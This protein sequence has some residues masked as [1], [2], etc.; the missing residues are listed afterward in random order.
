MCRSQLVDNL[1]RVRGML[2]DACRR[3][4]RSEEAVTLVGVTKYVDSRGAGE[5]AR[6]GCLDLGESRPQELVRKAQDLAPLPVRWHLVGHLQRNKV[7]QVLPYCALIHSVDSLRL[8]EAIGAHAAATSQQC[9]ILI[10]VNI[11]G[12]TAKTG[13]RSDD[14]APLLERVR[15][16]PL[17]SIRGFM[18]MAAI[19]A[20]EVQARAQ[21]ARLRELRDSLQRQFPEHNLNELS[22]GMSSDFRAAIGE[23]A[24]IVRI[25]S[26]LFEQR[27]PYS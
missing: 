22:M 11:S 27:A 14:A 1:S 8:L 23:G 24:T 18:G 5:L 7:K 15:A 21:F 4:G 13:I 9:N 19:D 2:A 16:F 17:V 25:G 12:E 10:E 6:A 26:L 20:T 3:V